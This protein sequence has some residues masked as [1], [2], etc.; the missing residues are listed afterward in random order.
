MAAKKGVAAKVAAGTKA[1]NADLIFAT[2]Q[3]VEN[4]TA[5]KAFTLVDELS[6]D[7]GQN[8]FKLG[9]VLS[10]ILAKCDEGDEAWLGEATSFKELCNT[11]FSLHYRKA[12]YLVSI[13][14]HLSEKSIPYS[15]FAGVSWTKI[16]VLAPVVTAKNVGTWVAKAKKLTYLQLVETVKKKTDT[17][18]NASESEGDSTVTTITFKLK[19]DQ[20][21]VV[22]EAIAKVKAETKT[23]FDSVAI[24]NLATGYLGGAV[25]IP[26][27]AGEP[28]AAS[29][30]KPKKQTKKEKKEAFKAMALELGLEDALGVIEE[31]FPEAEIAV[32]IPE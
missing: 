25:D 4:L 2:A 13:Y 23:E 14:R 28:E 6:N 32:T 27:T 20:K 11:R 22:K 18:K 31:A 21:E 9:G 12:M 5:A 24:T 29:T 8:D 30:D 10:T 26:T 1:A 17:G 16:A 15:E 3:E 7:I 19:P